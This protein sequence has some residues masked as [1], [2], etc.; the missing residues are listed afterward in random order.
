MPEACVDDSEHEEDLLLLED[1]GSDSLLSAS[2]LKEHQFRRPSSELKIEDFEISE[3]CILDER[4]PRK[5]ANNHSNSLGSRV[6]AY[7]KCTGPGNSVQRR[8][9]R[10][11]Y[12]RRCQSQDHVDDNEV[13]NRGVSEH[14][15]KFESMNSFDERRSLPG[16][17]LTRSE[18]FHQTR[19]DQSLDRIDEHRRYY[20]EDDGDRK[21]TSFLDT[22][23]KTT[24]P[25]SS[26]IFAGR[27]HDVL[28]FGKNRFNAG[29]YSGSN[30]HQLQFQ[31]KSPQHRHANSGGHARSK[32]TDV[33]SG[34]Y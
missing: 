20:P 31:A 15:R 32:V 8:T 23:R 13:N 5:S 3:T 17:G 11:K 21:Y 2:R 25:E 22:T 26:R 29:K 16:M 24:T 9:E 6:P 7:S 14:I 1:D 30:G 27:P 19:R 10:R 4:I 33:L 18:S 12:L 34:L 28:V